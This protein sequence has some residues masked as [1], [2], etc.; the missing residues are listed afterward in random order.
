[1]RRLLVDSDGTADDL[2]A[3]LIAAR[4]PEVDV[5]A[6]TAVAGA[7]RMSQAAENLLYGSELA[8]LNRAAVYPGCEGPLVRPPVPFEAMYGRTGLGTLTPPKPKGRPEGPH[9][10]D[11]ILSLA[12]H[13]RRDLQVVCLGPLT[14]LA[15]ALIQFPRLGDTLGQVYVYGGTL[16]DGNVT[17]AAEYNFYADPEAAALVLRSGLPLTLIP[18]DTARAALTMRPQDIH[19]IR[20]GGT[21]E[22]RFFLDATRSIAEYCRRTL[23]LVGSVLGAVVAMAVAVDPAVVLEEIQIRVDVE[24]RGDL[25][26]GA[27]VPDPVGLSRQPANVRLVRACDGDRIRE[28]LFSALGAPPVPEAPAEELPAEAVERSPGSS[29]DSPPA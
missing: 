8:G 14:N 18:W 6:I 25:T 11:A 23:R 28:H 20:A 24:A 21:R 5:V 26:R 4:S 19:R 13:Y 16:Q 3:L 2:L 9:A 12:R 10:V 1:M 15:A 22:G 27:V 29:A 17:P 7:V